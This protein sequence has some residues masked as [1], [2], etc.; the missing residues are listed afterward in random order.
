MSPGRHSAIVAPDGR[1]GMLQHAQDLAAA[2]VPFVFDPGPGFA[3]V[4]RRRP[5]EFHALATYACFND[6]EA[7]LLCDRTG[8]SLEQLAGEV[9]ALVVTLGGAGS[10][11]YAGGHCHEIPCVQ[12]EAVVDPTGMR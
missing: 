7:K 6:Y 12:A 10:H 1:D 4:F 8:R 11:I 5:D 9:E 2:A 3:D